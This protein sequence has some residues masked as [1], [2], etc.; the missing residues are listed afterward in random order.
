MILSLKK[1]K[2]AMKKIA[3]ISGLLFLGTAFSGEK[4]VC[5]KGHQSVSCKDVKGKKRDMF[6]WK[7]KVSEKKKAKLCKSEKRHK[8]KSKKVAK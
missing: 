4:Q 3:L 7:G 1:R 2:F 6:C 5:K 8:K